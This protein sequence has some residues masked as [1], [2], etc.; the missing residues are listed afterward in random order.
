MTTFSRFYQIGVPLEASK[1]FDFRCLVD[2]VFPL[3]KR[4]MECV[5]AI[6]SIAADIS[7]Q[8]VRWKSLI[9]KQ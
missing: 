4:R 9:D 5:G 1:S 2:G 7:A 6:P 8:Y 3:Q